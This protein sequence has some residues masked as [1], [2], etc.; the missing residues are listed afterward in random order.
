M[1]VK[2]VEIKIVGLISN[3]DELDEIHNIAKIFIYK[4]RMKDLFY[5]EKD[6]S[7]IKKNYLK[8]YKRSNINRKIKYYHL[9]QVRVR[10][11]V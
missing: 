6:E 5:V 9:Q 8:I 2:R 10:G 11:L 3:E 4:Q 1:E 7:L